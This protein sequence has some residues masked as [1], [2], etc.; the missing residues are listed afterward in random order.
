VPEDTPT[1]VALQVTTGKRVEFNWPSI[2]FPVIRTT[3]KTGNTV[4]ITYRGDTGAYT[5]K[6]VVDAQGG[7]VYYFDR[8]FIMKSGKLVLDEDQNSFDPRITARAEIRERD[9][10]DNEE[11]KIYLIADN[12]LSMFSPSFTSE[13]SRSNAEILSMIG[14]P[15]VSRAETQGI[16]VSAVMLGSDIPIQFGLLRPFEQK[17]REMLGLDSFSL[18]TQ[19]IQNLIASKLF[20]MET[21]PLDNTSLSLGK[22]LG[23]DLFVE[24]LIRMQAQSNFVGVPGTIAGLRADLEVNLEW[25]TPF[26]I[27]DWTFTPKTPQSLF[28]PDNAIS[29][30][31][32]ISY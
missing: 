23:N 18:R 8:S 20:G 32:R 19:V 6:G 17:V 26:F 16:G 9:P 1:F 28:I 7:E 24:M 10:K 30:N 15:I 22:Y 4:N 27:L 31:W 29:L 21:N 3:A 14:A 5:V 13:P 12:K 2:E 25:A 11:V